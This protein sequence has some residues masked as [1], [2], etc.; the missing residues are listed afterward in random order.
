MLLAL[1]AALSLAVSPFVYAACP[2]CGAS[3]EGDLGEVKRL[4][5]A[6]ADVNA[7]TGGGNTALMRVARR[8]NH[9]IVRL[10]LEAGANVN[11]VNNNG[12]TALMSAV[13]YFNPSTED[14]G[15][16]WRSLIIVQ[17]L[18]KAGANPNTA[19]EGRD[20]ALI[21]ATKSNNDQIVRILLDA[22]ADP[23][24]KG[25]Y[26]LIAFYYAEKNGN[27]ILLRWLK[28]AD[29]LWWKIKQWF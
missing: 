21:E 16:K 24:T 15:A 17:M 8:T 20:T 12:E 23:S 18:L 14:K 19:G 13:A 6:G 29:S 5:A 25:E 10:L 9:G 11:A 28:E 3:E 22:G 27:D 7:V 1:A 2:L 26:G 4:L